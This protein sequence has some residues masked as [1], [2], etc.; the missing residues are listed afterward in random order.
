[1]FLLHVLRGAETNL[2]VGAHVNLFC[3]VPPLFW[4]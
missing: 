3:R 4:L 1:L 2:K